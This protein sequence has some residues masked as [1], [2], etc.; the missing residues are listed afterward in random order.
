MG[1]I[2]DLKDFYIKG[3]GL[4]RQGVVEIQDHRLLFDFLDAQTL[5]AAGRVSC[6]QRRTHFK[7]FFGNKVFVDF[8]KSVG[9]HKPVPFLWREGYPLDFSLL[10]T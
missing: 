4:A 10:K 5:W 7:S 3:Q 2:L 6:H 1:S 8:L 9:I